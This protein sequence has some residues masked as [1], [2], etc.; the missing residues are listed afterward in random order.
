MS[1]K[2]QIAAMLEAL[3]AAGIK[4]KI[5]K[6]SRIYLNGY[7]RDIDAYISFDEPD[8]KAWDKSEDGLF[9]GCAVKVF[10]DAGMGKWAYNRRQDVM[11]R[12]GERLFRAGILPFAPDPDPRRMLPTPDDE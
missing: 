4:A 5:W 11:H 9:T 12:I 1:E 6:E 2:T 10:T 7:G 3:T 8:S